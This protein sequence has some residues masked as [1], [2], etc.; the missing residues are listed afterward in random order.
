M[1]KPYRD[2]VIQDIPDVL[3]DGQRVSAETALY[4]YAGPQGRGA[5]WTFLMGE[6]DEPTHLL[7]RDVKSEKFVSLEFTA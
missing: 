6:N 3:M 7:V 4:A 2:I 5:A 1:F